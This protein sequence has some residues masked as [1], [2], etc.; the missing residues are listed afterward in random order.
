[1]SSRL[2]IDRI[3]SDV[4]VPDALVNTIG[5]FRPAS[6]ADTTPDLLRTMMDI[7]L[8]TALWLSKAV[9]P[10]MQR[11]HSGAIVHVTARP[12]LE[13]TYGMAAYAASKAALVHLT[14]LLDV[15][16]RPLGIRVNSVAPQLMDTA[17]NRA[18]LPEEMLAH[19]V[20]PE[21]IAGII[22]FLVSDAAAPISGAGCPPTG[23]GVVPS[24]LVGL[25]HGRKEIRRGEAAKRAPFLRDFEDFLLGGQMVKVIGASDGL[26]QREVA[27]QN[28][29][30]SS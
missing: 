24:K 30:L 2:L 29:V 15:E 3:A 17:K 27:R 7:N 14:R 1:M 4:G 13:P 5:A 23:R 6:A 10:H 12:G 25:E 8:G 16:L 21:A 28:D 18:A 19:A 9:A 22:A 26:A 20:D 11:R